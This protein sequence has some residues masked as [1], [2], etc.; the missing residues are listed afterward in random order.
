MGKVPI[1]KRLPVEPSDGC[2]GS[3]NPTAIMARVCLNRRSAQDHVAPNMRPVIS[4]Q[5]HSSETLNGP[6]WLARRLTS[7]FTRIPLY[8]F[9]AG[10]TL[11]GPFWMHRNLCI[12]ANPQWTVLAVQLGEPLTGRFWDGVL[13][14]SPPLFGCEY[15]AWHD[16]T[17]TATTL[18]CWCTQFLRRLRTTP[19]GLGNSSNG[20]T[21]PLR[22]S[23]SRSPGLE[24]V[25]TCLFGVQTRSF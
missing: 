11:N 16:S 24:L 6:F 23:G 25:R 12:S 2:F 8:S 17:Y 4:T 3:S 7:N 13:C 22:P 20:V 18:A 9:T 10:R 14:P 19:S 15:G 1:K 5:W 21:V